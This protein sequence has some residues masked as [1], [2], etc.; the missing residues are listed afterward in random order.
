[1]HRRSWVALVC[2][3]LGL[4]LGFASVQLALA[5]S[6]D[7]AGSVP[8]VSPEEEDRGGV[9]MV[10]ASDSHIVL[11]VRAGAPKVTEVTLPDGS[12]C[13]EIL[14]NGYQSV[15]ESGHPALPVA[16]ATLGIPFSS[17]P[18][19][20]IVSADP[21]EL[22]GTYRLCPEPSP[23][24]DA[25][26]SDEG[27]PTQPL[28]WERRPDPDVYGSRGWLPASPVEVTDTGFS[29]D[30]RVAR[31]AIRPLQ[32]DPGSG[33]IRL[34]TRMTVEV[35]LNANTLDVEA[36]Q[37]GGPSTTAQAFDALLCAH[38]M[39]YDQAK[40][41]RQISPADL[42]GMVTPQMAAQA[43][44][45]GYPMYRVEVRDA[46]LYRLTYA[47]LQAA[48]PSVG[49]TQVDPRN[50]HLSTHGQEVAI[51]VT[52]EGDGTFDTNDTIYFYGEA[53]NTVYANTNVYWLTWDTTPGIRMVKV[54]ASPSPGLPLPTHF[55]TTM[56]LEEDHAYRR[57]LVTADGDNWFWSDLRSS[58][59]PVSRPYTF[60]IPNLAT[61]ID[62][63][64]LV[65]GDL[66]GYSANTQHS[67]EI[68]LNGRR[69]YTATW[70]PQTEH[71]FSAT[72]P[73]TYLVT[74]TNVMSVTVGVGNDSDYVVVN[75]FAISYAA[76]YT[77]TNDLLWFEGD[78]TGTWAFRIGG[79]TTD[80]I[81]VMDVTYP[82]TPSLVIGGAAE[83]DGLTYTQPFSQVIAAERRYL[84]TAYA[85]SPSRIS[86]VILSDLRNTSNAADYIVIAHGTVIT[87]AHTL[88][89]Y[90]AT[91]GLRTQVVNVQDVYDEFG[92]GI[93]DAA[94]IRDFLA[95][96]YANWT[97]PAPS[98]VVLFGDG[99]FDPKDNLGR[100]EP[101]LIPPY[102][103]PVD[104]WI[105][106]TAAD[107]LY[108]KF[109]DD[110]LP[111]MFIGRLPALTAAHADTLVNKIIAYEQSPAA[112]PWHSQILFVADNEDEGGYFDDDSDEV[113]DHYVP[114]PYT[115][116]K[117]YL[118]VTHD[119]ASAKSAITNAINAGRLIVNYAGHG[120]TQ[121]WAGERLLQLN[122][123][124]SLNNVDKLPFLVPMTCLEGYF[125]IPSPPDN[126]FEALS[127][128]L[129]RH[130]DGGAIASWSATGLGLAS[131]H[132]YLDR[133]I[134]E[135]VFYRD[136]IE[137]GPA[138]AYA[139]GYLAASSQF[140]NDLLDTYTLFGD[141][142][143][144]LNVLPADLA[145]AKTVVGNAAN[146]TW[147]DPIT[148]TLTYTNAGPAT[149]HHVVISDTLPTALTTLAWSASGAPVTV[150]EQVGA[151]Y[152]WDAGSLPAGSGGVITITGRI[153]P[154]LQT[155]LINTVEITTTTRE[156]ETANNRSQS[157]VLLDPLRVYLPLTLR[158]T[159]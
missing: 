42:P 18:E 9:H 116:E 94:A 12:T 139:K 64:A 91:Q 49:W 89:D 2:V 129:V 90:R 141:P 117:V 118:G 92:Y 133:G 57:A 93:P 119:I 53:I 29:R 103:A 78:Q 99:N 82:L 86:R 20:R 62:T 65:S 1:M 75:R 8:A 158:G 147:G 81:K 109:D 56:L 124:P 7:R 136:I 159:R 107:N 113:A 55:T 32:Y 108:V 143:T 77:A 17:H 39:N 97:S 5:A 80:T 150:T 154:S 61:A 114:L 54:D 125:I 21:I 156:I 51:E 104:P 34:Y 122:S 72:I 30:Q 112:S 3:G 25:G 101:S 69:I 87:A 153:S 48:D 105:R 137:L 149:A 111:D 27:F 31:I 130:P 70:M 152:A 50:L 135:A 45:G 120:A 24:L 110:L 73:L 38:L 23:I 100:G 43:V 96:T 102:L 26:V 10:H 138:T 151:N 84:T 126:N 52:G 146:F 115:V 35:A 98:Y 79:F 127:E 142:A 41:W 76:T 157:T 58:G 19:A 60:T 37:I 88:A 46:G 131:G 63:T 145:I 15:G 66:L 140:F 33:K 85:L 121:L 67:A 4:A 14:V 128:A 74:G 40:A 71:M 106:E 6:R 132:D 47:D 148:Y 144:R 134:F 11:S 44:G 16:S 68:H 28:G 59:T 13:Q 22:P 123:L 83:F 155:T 36:A 95:Y